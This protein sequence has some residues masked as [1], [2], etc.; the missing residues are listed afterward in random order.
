MAL[1]DAAYFI[2]AFIAFSAALLTHFIPYLFWLTAISLILMLVIIFSSIPLKLNW[3]S[4]LF[5]HILWRFL[6][7]LIF[8]I[9][10]YAIC[11]YFV[12]F[13]RM[14]GSRPSFFE[15]IYFSVTTFTTLQY[16]Q[17]RPLPQSNPLVCIQSLMAVVVFL[18]TFAA[19]SWLYCSS[20]LWP[21]TVEDQ[22][23]PK[24]L[25]FQHDPVVGG[26]RE[27]ESE[28]SIQE[29]E[30]L[31]KQVTAVPCVRCGKM[32]K[33]EKIYHIVGRITPLALFIVHCSC[34]QISKPS[35]IAYLAAWRWKKLN[36]KK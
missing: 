31:N 11:Y 8:M 19:Y 3:S 15:A 26:W 35:H 13:E 30:T 36:R 32:P 5:G 1:L 20:R 27:K 33:I 9:G 2:F 12:G 10:T 34:G 4:N 25:T 21:Q 24:E 17:Y 29:Q 6:S 28:K 16:G 23:V 14:D 18:P 22:S 7:Y